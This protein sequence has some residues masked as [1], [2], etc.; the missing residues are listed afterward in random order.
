MHVIRTTRITGVPPAGLTLWRIVSRSHWTSMAH[1]FTW[2]RRAVRRLWL[3]ILPS[4]RSKQVTVMLL[5]SPVASIT[6]GTRTEYHSDPDASANCL[7][8]QRMGLDSLS[9]AWHPRLGGLQAIRLFRRWVSSQTYHRYFCAHASVTRFIKA[10]GSVS[11]VIKP[12][13]AALASNDHIYAVVGFRFHA[14]LFVTLIRLL[15][16]WKCDQC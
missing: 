15:D 10:E 16:G 5:S 14:P 7:F 1:R 4:D 11:I 2:M 13:E 8:A 9:L 3:H 12:L 6:S